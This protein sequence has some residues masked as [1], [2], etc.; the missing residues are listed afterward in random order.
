MELPFWSYLLY[1]VLVGPP[2]FYIVIRYWICF[3]KRMKEKE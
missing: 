2:A 3:V 1:F